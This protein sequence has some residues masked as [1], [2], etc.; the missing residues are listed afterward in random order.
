ML[1]TEVKTSMT[2]NILY[3]TVKPLNSGHKNVL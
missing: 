2:S 3:Y 1:Q